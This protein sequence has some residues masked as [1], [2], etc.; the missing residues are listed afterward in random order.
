MTNIPMDPAEIGRQVF[1]AVQYLITQGH[2]APGSLVVLGCSTSEI[3]GGHIG[4]SGSPELGTTVVRAAMDACRSLGTTLAVQCCEHLNRAL[5]M[6]RDAAAARGYAPVS[7]VPYPSAGGSA[8]SAAY[9]LLPDPVL[10][11]SIQADAGLDIGDTLIG[12]HLK[13]VAVP[14]RAPCSAIGQAHLVMA[15][16]RPKYI[17]GPRTHYTLEENT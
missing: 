9:R 12:M 3:S 2:V 1:D 4:K 10:V 7:A 6:P 5:V 11:E 14:L 17:G 8:A 16:T 13:A 15:F